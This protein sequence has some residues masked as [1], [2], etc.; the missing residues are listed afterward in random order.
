[1]VVH[2][3]AQLL[4]LNKHKHGNNSVSFIK[5]EP[6]VHAAVTN[7][8][9]SLLKMLTYKVVDIHFFKKL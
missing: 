8:V 9:K 4:N 5:V 3:L 1:M 6:N 2:W 7:Y